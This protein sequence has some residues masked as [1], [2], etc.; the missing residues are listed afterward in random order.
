MIATAKLSAI[1]WSQLLK[2]SMS[3][4][5]GMELLR[6]QAWTIL[7]ELKLSKSVPCRPQACRIG[8]LG[9]GG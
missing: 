5:R 7:A 1:D 9:E 4:P 2:P 6:G 3:I 8:F